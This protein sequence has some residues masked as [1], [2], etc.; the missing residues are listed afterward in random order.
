MAEV[1]GR[2]APAGVSVRRW[3]RRT[4]TKTEVG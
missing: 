4:E 3:L 1:R 2:R